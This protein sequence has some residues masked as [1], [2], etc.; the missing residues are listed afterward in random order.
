MSQHIPDF[1]VSPATLLIF[2]PGDRMATSELISIS[3]DPAPWDS[4]AHTLNTSLEIQSILTTSAYFHVMLS[5]YASR[6]AS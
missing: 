4:W 5:E 3:P 1:L 2:L 6:G